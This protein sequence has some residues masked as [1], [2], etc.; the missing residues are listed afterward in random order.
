MTRIDSNDIFVCGFVVVVSRYVGGRPK[1]VTNSSIRLRIK[2][3]IPS[4]EIKR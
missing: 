3:L 4:K 2:D 1:M